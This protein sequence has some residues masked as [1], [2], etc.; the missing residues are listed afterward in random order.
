[1]TSTK[2][3][4]RPYSPLEESLNAITHGL[5]FIA[6]IVG[7][8]LMLLRADGIYGQVVS[9]V[10]GV[11]MMMMFLSSTLYHGVSH[12]DLKTLLKT[13]DHS[14]IYVLIA[15][16]YT[17]LMV[18]AVGGTV[19]LVAMVLIWSIAITGIVFKC[20]ANNRFPKLSLVTYLLMGWLAI[21]FVYPL[22]NS[23]ESAGFYLL[24]AGGLCYTV[25]VVFY[26]AKKVQFTHAIWHLFVA[27]GCF[28]HYLTIYCY[29]I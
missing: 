4:I 19:G 25:G 27:A 6:A 11:S 21:F 28:C 14:A 12:P 2:I 3:A 16:T 18:L 15:G 24:L 22:Y 13:I 26:A 9:V 20:F 5:G 1:M 23:L 17:P 8:V 29:V 10:F 7:L